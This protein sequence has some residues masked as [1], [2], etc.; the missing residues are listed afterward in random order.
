MKRCPRAKPHDWTHCP[1]AHPGEKA[2]RRDPRRYR[3]SGTGELGNVRAAPRCARADALHAP[4]PSLL[5]RRPPSQ[6]LDTNH[7]NLHFASPP[8]SVPGVPA[9]KFN[10]CAGARVSAQLAGVP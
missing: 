7:S 2:K 10:C 5:V 3:Y 9:G 1:F 8:R 4:R 6:Q